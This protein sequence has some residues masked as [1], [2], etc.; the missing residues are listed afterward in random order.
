M[1]EEGSQPRN[2]SISGESSSVE[3]EP[4]QGYLVFKKDQTIEHKKTRQQKKSEKDKL[5]NEKD[6]RK[7]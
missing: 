6:K 7:L 3:D 5:K 2:L 1:L 4:K